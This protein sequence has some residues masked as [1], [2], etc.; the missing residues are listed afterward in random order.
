MKLGMNGYLC[1]SIVCDFVHVA[2]QPW[3]KDIVIEKY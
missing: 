3:Q 1:S 2:P